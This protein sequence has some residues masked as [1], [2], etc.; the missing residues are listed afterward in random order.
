MEPG[1]C[2]A[3][4]ASLLTLTTTKETDHP[5]NNNDDNEADFLNSNDAPTTNCIG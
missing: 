1:K 4:E 3:R 5:M 2:L